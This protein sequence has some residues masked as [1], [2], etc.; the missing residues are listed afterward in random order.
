MR[1]RIYGKNAARSTVRRLNMIQKTS[2]EP[3][4]FFNLRP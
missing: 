4:S 2:D 3:F 1:T